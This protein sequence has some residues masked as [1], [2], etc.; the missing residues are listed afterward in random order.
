MATMHKNIVLAS[1]GTVG[2]KAAEQKTFE[3]CS[4]TS[5]ITHLIVVPEF[6][7]DMLGDDWLNNSSTR[8]QFENYLASELEQELKQNI[9]RVRE[10]S[11][12]LSFLY[13]EKIAVGDPEKCLLNFNDQFEF[14]LIVMGSK[15]PK[16]LPGLYSHML[17][18]RVMQTLSHKLITTPHP[19]A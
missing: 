7:K 16:S 13:T 14:D 17:S 12:K 10:Q 5:H 9:A 3:L 8:I 15:R 11:N 18:D 6:W 2:A 19:N 4:L 1:H